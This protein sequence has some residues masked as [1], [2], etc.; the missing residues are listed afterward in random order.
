MNYTIETEINKPFDTVIALFNDV[1]N[2]QKWMPGIVS[3][4]ILKG[5]SRN[6]DTQ[7]IFIF[8]MG[9]RTFEMEETVLQ[10]D[11]TEIMSKFI[12]NGVINMQ[13]THFSEI[14]EGKTLYRVHE[15]FQLKGFMKIIGFLMP[16]SFKKQTGQFVDAFK[17]FVE[18][19][20]YTV[21]WSTQK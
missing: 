3:H 20:N 16:G 7:S 17:E 8:K 12:A 11:R 2:Y 21:D 1:D 14:G 4:T 19:Q 6:I 15:S 18:S 5:Q 13:R 10:N 9:G